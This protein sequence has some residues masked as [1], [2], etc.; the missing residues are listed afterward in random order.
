MVARACI[1]ECWQQRQ[2]D[3]CELEAGLCNR[4]RACV[5]KMSK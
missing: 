5:A 3:H 1:P 2:E 4:V